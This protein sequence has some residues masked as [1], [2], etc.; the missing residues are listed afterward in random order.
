MLL[1][2]LPKLGRTILLGLLCFSFAG[3]ALAGAPQAAPPQDY[4]KTFMQ[5]TE[6]T[7]KMLVA[8]GTITSQQKD[9]I[10]DMYKKK[11]TE[12]REE[13]KKTKKMTPAEREAYSKSKPKAARTHNTISDLINAAGLSEAQAKLVAKELYPQHHSSNTTVMQ[14]NVSPRTGQTNTIQDSP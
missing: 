3:V 8:Q 7:L 1:I 2:P 11:D 10:I 5:H 4:F 9:K 14:K 13:F 6:E 12:R